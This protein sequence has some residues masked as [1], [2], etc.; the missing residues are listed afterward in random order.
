MKK[1]ELIK[2]D[3]MVTSSWGD[4]KLDLITVLYELIDINGHKGGSRS[5]WRTKLVQT[6]KFS[7]KKLAEFSKF[8]FR[9]VRKQMENKLRDNAGKSSQKL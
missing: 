2:N 5:K 1:C 8:S 9:V 7:K 6:E 4:M 3:N